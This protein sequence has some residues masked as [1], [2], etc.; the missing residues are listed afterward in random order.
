MKT[1]SHL[2]HVSFRAALY[3]ATFIQR[4]CYGVLEKTTRLSD[5]RDT[6]TVGVIKT[7]L[8]TFEDDIQD[9]F[10]NLIYFKIGAKRKT[11][12]S[13]KQRRLLGKPTRFRYA[14]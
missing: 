2:K 11:R 7:A 1:V 6:L 12:V 3:L 9:V 4:V 8:E 10:S 13:L 5:H 14:V